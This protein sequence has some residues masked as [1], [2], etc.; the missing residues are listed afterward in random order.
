MLDNFLKNR[1]KELGDFIVRMAYMAEIKEWDNRSHI[2]RMRRYCLILGDGVGISQQD[3][4][5]ISTASQLHDI[6][7]IMMPDALMNRSTNYTD[8]EKVFIERHTTDGAKILEDAYSPVLQIAGTIARTHH[9]RWDG[10]GYPNGLKKE[11]IPLGGRICALADVFDALTT[12]RSYK[13]I[14]SPIDARNLILESS[15]ILFDPTLVQVFVEKFND[16]CKIKLVTG[17]LKMAY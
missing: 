9:E 5:V 11:E 8:A 13:P 7:K 2:E 14:I 4:D 16:I 17:S 15:G 1:P 6:G 12:R 10:S 3:N